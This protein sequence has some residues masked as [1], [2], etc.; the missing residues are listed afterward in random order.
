[1]LERIWGKGNTP[2]LL[3]EVQT[4]SATLEITMV[5]SQKIRKQSTSIASNTTLGYM[6]KGYSI[7]PQ[8]HVLSYV[9]SSI[10]CNIQNLETTY[11]SLNRRMDLKK[12][13]IYTMEYYTPVKSNDIL[14]FAGKKMDLKKKHTG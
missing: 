3:G 5:I 14:K 13:Y 8:G 11:M 12:K 9:H 4:C 10:I 6:P 2:A 1:M 7:V